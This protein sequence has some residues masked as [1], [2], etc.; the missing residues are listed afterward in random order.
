MLPVNLR[1]AAIG[2]DRY[3]A[4]CENFVLVLTRIAVLAVRSAARDAADQPRGSAGISRGGALW[5][6]WIAV[7]LLGPGTPAQN[8]GRS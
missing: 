5:L 7:V 8:Q 2:L 4:R 6:A 1:L 3:A